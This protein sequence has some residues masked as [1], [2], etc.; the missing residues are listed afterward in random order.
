MP[1]TRGAAIAASILTLLATALPAQVETPGPGEMQSQVARTL[2]RAEV[3]PLTA[4]FA[5]GTELADI[6]DSESLARAIAQAAASVG[7]RGRLA[8]AVGLRALADGDLYGKEILELLEP[9]TNSQAT[10]EQAAALSI[11]ADATLFNS[12]VLPDVRTL[13]AKRL[14]DALAPAD[15][16]IEAARALWRIGNQDQSLQAKQ[17][18]TGFLASSDHGTSLLAALT[19]AEFNSDLTGK[20][21]SILRRAATEPTSDGRLAATYLQREEERRLFQRR[22]RQLLSEANEPATAASD[23]PLGLIRELMRLAESEHIRGEA[24]KSDDMVE[25]A[26][27]GLLQSLDPHSTFFTS[28]EFQ[29]F[30]FDLNREYGGIGAFVN[31]DRDGIFSITR[32]IYSGPAYRAGLRS[33]DRIFEVDGWETGGRTSEEIISRLKGQPNTSVVLKV[34]RPGLQEPK[35]VAIT[36]QEIVVPSVN[37]EMLPGD[38]GYA[39]V[40]TFAQN[41]GQELRTAISNLRAQGMTAMILDLRND[42]GGYLLAARDV[43][44][45][46][47]PGDK[48]VV[49]TQGRTEEKQEYR[50][51]PGRQLVTELPLC[52][53]VNEFTASASEITAGALQDHGRAKIVGDRSYGKG[54]VQ[55][56]MSLRSRSPEPFEDKNED[57]VRNEWETYTDLN[58]N[59]KYDPG[60]H[61]KVTIAR[62]YLPSGRSIH[63]EIDRDGRIIAPDWGIIPDVAIE[64]REVSAKDAWKNAELFEIYQAGKLQEYSK[65]LVTDE[66]QLCLQLAEGDGGDPSKYPGFEEFFGGLDTHL[67]RDDI[68]RWVRYLVRDEVA[69]LRGKAYPGGRALGDIQEDAQLQEA[70]R[71]VLEQQGKDIRDLE[72]LRSV[73][74]ISFGDEPESKTPE[75]AGKSTAKR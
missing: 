74:K 53:L 47:V 30:F 35:D 33:G 27:K 31:F 1:M 9:V 59:G 62:Y 37:F 38:I 70:M 17:T 39:E 49:Y 61:V 43:V 48:L 57:G 34:M 23:D 36:R 63:K 26:A 14:G 55:Q 2:A 24:F 60:A 11:L 58:D 7:N 40:V 50:T 68:R 19:L 22:L 10:G 5:V 4:V 18:L 69:D 45:M 64:L 29:R 56:I 32:P 25:S 15:A 12:R 20:L 46:F 41:T 28:D 66:P 52:V 3:G 42:T 71:Q 72:G 6:G 8:A 65:K 51:R 73:L 21:G 16:Q 75:T 13:V 54:S 67:D 44:E